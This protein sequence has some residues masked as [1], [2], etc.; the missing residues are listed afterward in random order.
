M[1][2]KI[3]IALPFL[4]ALSFVGGMIFYKILSPYRQTADVSNIYTEIRKLIKEH[5]VENVDLDSLD[6][7]LV[8][9]LLE[10]LDPHSSYIPRSE[11]QNLNET[12]Q[13]S[14][15][16]IGV[17]FIIYNDTVVVVQVIKNG[18]SEHIGL[19]VGDR[20]ISVNDSIIA[21]NGI[22]NESVISL[23]KG[24]SGSNVSIKVMRIGSSDTHTYNIIRGSVPLESVTMA[25]MLNDT[26]AYI[27]F[28][29]FAQSTYEEFMSKMDFFRTQNMRQIIVD[30]R[31][32]G[33][34][35]LNTAIQ[36]INEFLA[37]GDTIVYTKGSHSSDWV[38]IATGKGS[39]QDIKVAILIDE[40]SASASEIFAG[41]IQDNSRG[42]IVGRRSFGKGVVNEDFLLK[43]GSVLRLTIEKFYTPSGRCIQK[44]YNGTMSDYEK[45][46]LTRYTHGELL[47]SD[48]ITFPDSLIYYTRN[49]SIV[50]G[51]GGIMPDIFVPID[52]ISYS[53]LFVRLLDKGIF[54]DYAL[55]FSKEY[56]SPL[57]KCIDAE[58]VIAF[59]NSTLSWKQY[60]AFAIKHGWTENDIDITVPEQQEI[61]KTLSCYIVR[62]LLGNEEC[63]KIFN[64]DDAAILAAMKALSK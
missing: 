12:I 3:L 40:S 26:T 21:G 17:Q 35:L 10:K 34:G 44:P 11:Y 64:K 6:I 20:I 38:R 14:F 29:C 63:Y 49:G 59:C 9:D 19:Q 33:G 48:S 55:V 52:S 45:E 43:N 54:I 18:P 16:G 4:L 5:Y 2:N 25:Y 56:A 37:E 24:P 53:D 31:G 61:L 1:K 28:D 62:Q 7:L 42:I 60:S 22:T 57:S 8:P 47:E 32:N 23:L 39:L 46:I 13:G 50:Y 41:S 58:S 30:L 15:D 27:A 51:G 36:I